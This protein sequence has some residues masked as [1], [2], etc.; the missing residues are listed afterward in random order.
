MEEITDF[1]DQYVEQYTIEVIE[2]D[3]VNFYNDTYMLLQYFLDEKHQSNTVEY[4]KF[5]NHITKNVT[6]LEEYTDF[7]FSTISDIN[8]LNTNKDVKQLTP[9]FTPYSFN[10]IEEMIDQIFEELKVAKEFQKELKEEI[11]YILEEYVF[12]LDHLEENMK[13]NFYTYDE[14]NEVSDENFKT[15]LEEFTIEKRKFIQRCNDRLNSKK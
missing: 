10:E 9:I 14:I 7:D 11:K 2:D 1:I 12:H 3:V 6:Y 13:F 4:K 15:F 8:S 5:I